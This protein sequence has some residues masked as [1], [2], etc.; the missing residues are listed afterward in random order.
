MKNWTFIGDVGGWENYHVGDEAMLE[1]NLD[2]FRK[3]DPT[4]C[5]TVVSSDPAFSSAVFGVEAV[6]R[7]GFDL[8]TNDDER[9]GL[10]TALSVISDDAVPKA[11]ERLT[12]PSDG[13]VIS[14]GGNLT[15]AWPNFICERLA[16]CRRAARVGA[17]I[18]LL[19]QTIG[20]ALEPR[21]RELV[22]EMLSLASWVGVREPHSFALA[23][24]LGAREADLSYQLDDAA[25]LGLSGASDVG[26]L[27]PFPVDE[28][29]IALTFHPLTDPMGADPLWDQLANQLAELA[30]RSCS[31][32]VFIP[33]AKAAP[34]LGAPWSDE[35]VGRALACRLPAGVLTLLPVLKAREVAALTGRAHMVVS[36]RYHPIVFGLAAAV[37]CLGVWTTEYTQ[38]KLQGALSHYGRAGDACSI[39]E[40]I[41]GGLART[42][43]AL[44]IDALSIQSSLTAQTRVHVTEEQLRKSRLGERI[45][46]NGMRELE[47]PRRLTAAL[48]YIHRQS[49][50]ARQQAEQKSAEIGRG[51]AQASASLDEATIYARSLELGRA[52]AEEY[53]KSLEVQLNT[54]ERNIA[55]YPGISDANMPGSDM[56]DL[57]L[58]AANAEARASQ[59]EVQLEARRK[60]MLELDDLREENRRLQGSVCQLQGEFIALS[61]GYAELLGSRTGQLAQLEFAQSEVN[62]LRSKLTQEEAQLQQLRS[63]LTQEEAQGFRLHQRLQETYASTSWRITR[64]VR[65]LKDMFRK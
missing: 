53:A 4:S 55:T 56:R 61:K 40:A 44:W 22:S 65:R 62:Q 9:E 54:E 12:A 46:E 20:P 17:K 49:D 33:H 45:L 30:V 21:H 26:T 18:F 34:S 39:E 7:L 15:S 52:E 41:G 38:V 13:L 43:C 31:R 14:G 16:F 59:L 3:L 24:E 37:P 60:D 32:L 50:R 42:A 25:N 5:L 28:P 57:A 36:S 6:P 23:L 51:L 27:L 1:A 63:K 19:G 29:W 10:L 47:S 11:F 48:A 35:D 2:L 64:P 58:E 8:C